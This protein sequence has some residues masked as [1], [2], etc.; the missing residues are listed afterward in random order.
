MMSTRTTVTLDSDV[1]EQ[2]K[3]LARCRDIS[4]ETALN[5]AIRKGLASERE[6][7]SPYRVPSRPMRLRPNIDLAHALSLADSIED[8]EILRKLEIRK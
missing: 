3:A 4:F 5:D 8:E 1:A 7:N 2:L 6:A